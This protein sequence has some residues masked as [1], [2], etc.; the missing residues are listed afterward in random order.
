MNVR[1]RQTAGEQA[2]ECLANKKE[3]LKAADEYK[4]LYKVPD[5]ENRQPF[6]LVRIGEIMFAAERNADAFVV[7][8]KV[9]SEYPRTEFACRSYYNLGNYEQTKTMNYEQAIVYYDSSFISRTIS[10]YGR[11]SRELR[12]AL[13]RLLALRKLNDDDLKKDD[14]PNVK[15]FFSNE[16]QIAELFLFKLSEVDSAVKRLDAII[17]KDSADTAKVMRAT[18]A[19]AF[20]YDEFKGDEDKAEELYKEI[21]EKYPNTEYAKQAQA[22]LG[23]RVTAKTPEDLAKERYLHAESLWTVASEIPLDQMEMVDSAYAVAF[24]AFDSVYQEFPNTETGAQALYMK[25]MYFQMSPERLDSAI[26]VYKEL[27]SKY[28][29]TPWGRQAALLTNQR[30]G[31]DDSDAMLERLRK[32]VKQSEEHIDQLSKQYYESMSKPPEEKKAEVKSKEDEVLE[33]TYNSM[34]DFE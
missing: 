8:Q 23:M 16:F 34:Y 7:L 29:G 9:N 5:Y 22:N 26:M 3:Y 15:N 28:P 10:E 32:R 21:I 30:R 12:D 1:E 27:S 19:R 2:A 13:K 18:Y 14:I 33:N 24:S 6:Y 17:E 20:I 25:A 11:K 31:G 4:A